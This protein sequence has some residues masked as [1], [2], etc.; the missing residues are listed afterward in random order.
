M[1]GAAVAGK[2]Y[3]QLKLRGQLIGTNDILI[4]GI[5]AA[6]SLPLYTRNIDHFSKIKGLQMFTP[7]QFSKH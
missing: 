7:Q 4:A 3:A 6:N 1:I 5:C 2:I